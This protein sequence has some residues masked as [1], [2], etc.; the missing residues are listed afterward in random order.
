MHIELY[1]DKW[2]N[3]P[4]PTT[5]SPITYNHDTLKFPD[6][7]PLPFPFVLEF[8]KETNNCTQK[9]LLAT[10]DYSLPPP[11]SPLALHNS[12]TDSDCLF[13]IQYLPENTLKS[14]WILV[15]INHIE[16][17]L[18]NMNAKRT[19]DYYVTFISRH[20]NDNKLYDDKARWWPLWHEYKNDKNDVP[21]YG[22]R[23]LFGPKRKS[24]SN[25]YIL[26]TDS[27]HLTNP[28]CYLDGKFLF[29]F[30]YYHS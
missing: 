2:F 16:T 25:K 13:F 30:R 27:V 9:L 14:C 17:A 18:L 10:G 6:K 4:N 21:I 20:P 7:Y 19:G 22:A 3:K 15:Q 1:N 8:H 26:W 5:D 11:P 12:L 29:I 24:D 23:M 28:S